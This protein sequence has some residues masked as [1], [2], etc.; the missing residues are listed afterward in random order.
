ME[1]LM[2]RIV[3]DHEKVEVPSD[4]VAMGASD[5]AV[6]GTRGRSAG[7]AIWDGRPLAVV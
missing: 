6:G 1:H 4:D 2:M 7:R 3:P 5:P